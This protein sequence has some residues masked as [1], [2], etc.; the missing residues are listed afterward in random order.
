[1][2]GLAVY[3]IYSQTANTFVAVVTLGLLIDA[4]VRIKTCTFGKLAVSKVQ[5]LWQIS[6]FFIYA[7]AQILLLAILVHKKIRGV[8]GK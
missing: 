5:V 4:F 6:S 8:T 3:G 2:D 7:T 1:L